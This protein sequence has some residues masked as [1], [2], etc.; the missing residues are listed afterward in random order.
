M[1]AVGF[2]PESS[3]PIHPQALILRPHDKFSLYF[4]FRLTPAFVAVSFL[5]I[6]LPLAG[7]GPLWNENLAPYAKACSNNWWTNPLYLGG[8]IHR[9][10][11]VIKLSD[12]TLAM[13]D[14]EVV[15]GV[16]ARASMR[17]HPHAFA[18]E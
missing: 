18:V 15:Q 10:N 2:R 13:S 3:F 11:M 16:T 8:Y 6:L 7:S 14:V 1:N 4:D 17:R 12:S 9:E 5:M